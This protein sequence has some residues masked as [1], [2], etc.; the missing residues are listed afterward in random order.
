M[1]EAATNLPGLLAP[2]RHEC[3]V[4][5][6]G[7][8][9]LRVSIAL[10]EALNAGETVQILRARPDGLSCLILTVE[11]QFLV[12]AFQAGFLARLSPLR[13]CASG[14]EFR[15]HEAC[16]ERNIACQR[17]VALLS[18][19]SGPGV[20]YLVLERLP[21][22]VPLAAYLER[23]K[24][25][26]L[27][28]PQMLRRLTSGLA[29][30]VASL[31]LGGVVLPDLGADRILV[32]AARQRPEGLE[33]FVQDVADQAPDA[34]APLARRLGNLGEFALGFVGWPA[35]VFVRF[36]R[37]YLVDA[38]DSLELR[39]A[40]RMVQERALA[41]QFERNTLLVARC[42]EAS[43]ALARVER[44]GTVL[45]VNRQTQ[46]LD[47]EQLEGPLSDTPPQSWEQVLHQHLGLRL[48]ESSL[49]SARLDVKAGD[50]AQQ[51]RRVESSWGRLLEL[52][53][54]GVQAPR[55][56]ACLMLPTAVVVLGRVLGGLVPFRSTEDPE[57]KLLDQLTRSL[58]RMHRAGCYFLPGEP[59]E[60]LA[61]LSV[62]L[63]PRGGREFVFSAPWLLFRGTPG[64]LG[65][66][67]IAS[68]GRVAR[69]LSEAMGERVGR[70]LVW[71]YARL[72][73]LSRFDGEM[74]AQEAS[75]V[76]T[77]RTL[78]MTR[79]IERSRL[80]RGART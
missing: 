28:N 40:L 27:G 46:G 6:G 66:Q 38:G 31:H 56:L 58:I 29:R 2:L 65:M 39:P 13:F 10:R 77:G 45:L 3:G 16:R 19:R 55:P 74:L 30:F 68:L 23:E 72:L 24:E 63:G 22:T 76:P 54:V 59:R 47:L 9:A 53:Q 69:A 18:G 61:G 4:V 78:V 52:S 25:R 20:N 1:N 37:E 73:R 71:S 70:E 14:A 67:G 49:W 5:A 12:K 57:W 51:S 64:A 7:D 50:R 8:E 48:G 44:E 75:R 62:A 33:F 26:L 11:G 60:V 35:A 32:R 17:P 42:S 43:A 34:M 36:L 15:A 41:R 21:N 80:E 79:G